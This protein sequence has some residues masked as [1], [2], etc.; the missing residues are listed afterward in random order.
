M[1]QAIGAMAA[2]RGGEQAGRSGQ[3]I[4]ARLGE[5]VAGLAQE[6]AVRRDVQAL[7]SLDGRTL[8]DLGISRGEVERA[9]RFG[10]RGALGLSIA[11]VVARP[12]MPVSFSEWR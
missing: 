4:L 9:V 11:G 8:A 1:A 6:W 3:G 10:R 12:L 5:I 2:V 7:E